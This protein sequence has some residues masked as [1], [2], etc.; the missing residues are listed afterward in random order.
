MFFKSICRPSIYNT[1]RGHIRMQ[2][3]RTCV[4]GD[5]S[6]L[7]SVEDVRNA[8]NCE[9]GCFPNRFVVNISADLYEKLRAADATTDYE[10][11]S[12]VCDESFFAVGDTSGIKGMLA[13]LHSRCR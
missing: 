12:D 2:S 5:P 6:S 10:V 13:N 9:A 8:V 4:V 3:Y 11:H 7:V 1:I